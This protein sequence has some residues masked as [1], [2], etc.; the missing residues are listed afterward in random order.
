MKIFL[1]IGSLTSGGAERV[2]VF[3]AEHWASLGHEV[4]LVTMHPKERDFY[5]LDSSVCRIS[6]ER[7]GTSWI[8]KIRA[9]IQGWIGLR[10][11]IKQ[12]QP[13]VMV[14]MMTSSVV[15]GIV[16]AIGL[17]VRVYGSERNYPPRQ[18][19]NPVWAVLRRFVY[20]FADGHIAQTQKTGAWLEN[21]TGARNIKVILNPVAWPIHAFDPKI[22]PNQVVAAERK[23]LLAVGTKPI[24][25]GFDLLVEAFSKLTSGYPGWDLV[26]LGIDPESHDTIGGGASVRELA[27]RLGIA[28]RLFMPGKVGNTID[29]YQRADLFVLSSRYEGIPNVLLEAMASGCPS[30]AFDCDTGPREIIQEGVNGVLV[31]PESVEGL[32]NGL[33]SLMDDEALRKKYSK[34]GLKVRETFSEDKIIGLWSEAIGLSN[35]P[36]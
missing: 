29:W 23:I 6:F 33:A 1:Y 17:P 27:E 28:H 12:H 30:I 16:A 32:S 14:A 5:S 31:S 18:K 7:S 13:D 22:D 4:M 11:A 21:V 9:N 2:T 26:I 25:K 15:L 10:R 35:S 34:N 36:T 19:I 8:D 3:L 20:R 24:Q